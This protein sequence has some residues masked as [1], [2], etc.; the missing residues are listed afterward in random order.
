MADLV[1]GSVILESIAVRSPGVGSMWEFTF[2]VDRKEQPA[3]QRVIKDGQ[4]A[5]F[6]K[7]LFAMDLP[8]KDPRQVG[9]QV[10]IQ[11]LDPSRSDYG[12]GGTTI[13][14]D[15]TFGRQVRESFQAQVTERGGSRAG[16]VA[17]LTFNLVSEVRGGTACEDCDKELKDADKIPD[18]FETAAGEL[19]AMLIPGALAED[20]GNSFRVYE[21]ANNDSE[22]A[23][24]AWDNFAKQLRD[25]AAQNTGKV[26]RSCLSRVVQTE[27]YNDQLKAISADLIPLLDVRVDRLAR[28]YMAFLDEE[29]IDLDIARYEA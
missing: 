24:I 26:R 4:T 1:K 19:L 28:P 2:W 12:N 25:C 7:T 22:L 15:T 23:A 13:A 14:I 6:R 8:A 18:E 5:S 9:I 16:A 21:T 10:A 3:F 17:T 11:E 20:Y 27:R 29:R